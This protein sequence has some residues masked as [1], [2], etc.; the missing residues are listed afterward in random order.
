MKSRK[1]LRQ[2]TRR[3]LKYEALESRNLLAADFGLRHNFAE[4]ADVNDDGA[5][6]PSDALAVINELNADGPATGEQPMFSDVNDDGQI[7]PIDC[8]FVINR[9]GSRTAS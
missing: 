5:L 4:P 7:A 2:R 3:M 6:S 9:S 8:L 1:N